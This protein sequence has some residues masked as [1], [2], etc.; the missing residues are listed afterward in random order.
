MKDHLLS[1]H[2]AIEAQSHSEHIAIRARSHSQRIAIAK[3]KKHDRNTNA[4][5]RIANATRTQIH[6]S[7]IQT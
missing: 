6:A 2:I 7:A 4:S 3:R 5:Q 1:E